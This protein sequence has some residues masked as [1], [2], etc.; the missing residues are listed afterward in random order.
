MMFSVR[1]AVYLI[2]TPKISRVTHG[3]RFIYNLANIT[4]FSDMFLESG[5]ALSQFGPAL[6]VYSLVCSNTQQILQRTSLGRTPP[7]SG[8]I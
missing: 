2:V 8:P 3:V 4:P 7:K 5:P 1:S 6:E